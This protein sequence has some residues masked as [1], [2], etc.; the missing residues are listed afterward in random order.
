MKRPSAHASPD[1]PAGLDQGLWFI[2]LG[3]S[4]EI[5]MNFNLYGCDGKWLIVECG[6]TFGDES[7]PGSDLVVPEP[8]AVAMRPRH[9]ANF[10]SGDCKFD[11]DPLSGEATDFKALEALGRENVLAL[12]GDSTNVLTE[13]EAG[14]ERDVRDSLMSLFGRF[15]GR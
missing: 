7:D 13:G 15:T 4:G 12:V 1:L 3:G 10:H 8:N 11:P 14:S 9:G 5:G 2:P 6:V